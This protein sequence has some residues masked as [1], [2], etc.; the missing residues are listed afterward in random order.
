M[1]FALVDRVEPGVAREMQSASEWAAEKYSVRFC[2]VLRGFEKNHLTNR[3]GIC[4]ST[5]NR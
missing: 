2:A 4:Y 5:R 3:A 1:V